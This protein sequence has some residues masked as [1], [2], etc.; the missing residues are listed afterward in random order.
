MDNKHHWSD[1]SAGSLIG[2]ITASLTT[3]YVS[4]LMSGKEASDDDQ[5]PSNSTST[6]RPTANYDL[7]AHIP[8]DQPPRDSSRDHE[9]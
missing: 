2:V 7:E 6:R 3:R 5:D 8:K 1:V 4:T 9:Q